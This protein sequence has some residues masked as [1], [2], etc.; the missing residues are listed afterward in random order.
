MPGADSGGAIRRDS[1]R[2]LRVSEDTEWRLQEELARLVYGFDA[3]ADADRTHRDYLHLAA[4]ILEFIARRAEH[5]AAPYARM[6]E[7][8]TRECTAL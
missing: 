1:C 5:P 6:G 8:A 7:P 3:V 4:H 2:D